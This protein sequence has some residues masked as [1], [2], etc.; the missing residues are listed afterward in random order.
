MYSSRQ[1]NR[2][3]PA[4]LKLREECGA[5][6]RSLRE[7]AGISQRE[8]SRQMGFGYYS[9]IS[10]VET[11]R[12]RIPTDQ[13]EAW[14]KLCKVPPRDFARMLLKYYDPINYRLIFDEEEQQREPPKPLVDDIATGRHVR[15]SKVV[16]L[17]AR[18]NRLEQKAL[19]E[20]VKRLEALLMQQK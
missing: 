8:F 13:I 6:L 2:E 10:Q 14:A 18:I 17:D 1:H 16:P 5:W 3:S 11:G 15:S 12:G 4:V 19:E 7:A 20:R 9:F